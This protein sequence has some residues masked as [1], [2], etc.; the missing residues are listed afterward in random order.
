MTAERIKQVADDEMK[1]RT[2]DLQAEFL[3][4]EKRVFWFTPSATDRTSG[5]DDFVF[6]A[7]GYHYLPK[8]LKN[9]LGPYALTIRS[10]PTP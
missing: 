10:L 9:D 1:R 5:W 2:V 7:L 3:F 4:L 8:D 6:F